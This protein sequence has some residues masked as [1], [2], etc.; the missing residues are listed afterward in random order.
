M[1]VSR[2]AQVVGLVIILIGVAGL[3]LGDSRSPAC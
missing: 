1:P 3:L 2:Y